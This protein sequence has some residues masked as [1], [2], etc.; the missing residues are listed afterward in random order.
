MIYLTKIPAVVQ[1]LYPHYTWRYDRLD[2]SLFLSFDDGPTPGVT[3]WVLDVLKEFG[4]KATF[5]VLG[6]NVRKH[7]ELVHRAIDEGHSIGNHG[8]GHLNGWDTSTQA[9]LH[10]IAKANQTLWE[11]TGYSSNLFRP[12]YGRIRKEQARELRR[13]H[14]I[15]MMDVISGDFDVKMDGASCGK[16]VIQ[17]ARPGSIILMH[18]SHKAAPRMKVALPMFLKALLAEGYAFAPIP[19]RRLKAALPS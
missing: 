13:Q 17:H 19:T 16:L 4:V 5:F 3:D 2:P 11:Y 12:P 1:R 6:K 7:P 15:V 8:Y 18:D 10:D 9:Y 14:E